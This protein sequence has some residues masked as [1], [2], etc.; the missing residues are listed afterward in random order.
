[1]ITRLHTRCSSPQDDDPAASSA[2]LL[3]LWQRATI[4]KALASRTQVR[5]WQRLQSL[6]GYRLATFPTTSGHVPVLVVHFGSFTASGV[7]QCDLP[8][9]WT[10]DAM[11]VSA[12]EFFDHPGI[13]FLCTS[14]HAHRLQQPQHS[15]GIAWRT[16]T[17][18]PAYQS[19][20]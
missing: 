19:I 3:V 5:V 8:T 20:G 9:T 11:S 2:V 7:N 13:R 18:L 1:M 17:A 15:G 12:K 16:P 14:Q 6:W 10:A 4:I